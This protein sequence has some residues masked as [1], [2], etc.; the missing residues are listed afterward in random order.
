[1]ASLVQFRPSPASCV[2]AVGGESCLTPKRK[3]SLFRRHAD[4]AGGLV[5]VARSRACFRA[6]G[7][8]FYYEAKNASYYK[9]LTP[10]IAKLYVKVISLS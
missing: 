3:A 8:A 5:G 6:S 9:A 7:R 4:T 10:L 2:L 1:M